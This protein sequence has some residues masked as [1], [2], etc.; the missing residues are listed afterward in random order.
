LADLRK[1]LEEE[2]VELEEALEELDLLI[3]EQGSDK[4]A[5]LLD[6]EPAAVFARIRARCLTKAEA[7]HDRSNCL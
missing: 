6:L 2:F 3:A 7:S 1:T 4:R 5:V